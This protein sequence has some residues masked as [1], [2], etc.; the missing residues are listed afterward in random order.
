M[1]LRDHKRAK[2]TDIIEYT[3]KQNGMGQT[4]SRNE[5]QQMDQVLH[6]VATKEREE[7]KGTTKQKMARQHMKEEGNPLEQ[8]RNREK[9][10]ESINGELQL[11]V[12]G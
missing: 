1:M 2:L 12:D 9:I 6:R 7:I 11:A 5:A 8:E 4:Y 3:L 10:M